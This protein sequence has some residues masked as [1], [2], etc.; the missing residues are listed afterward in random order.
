M[1]DGGNDQSKDTSGQTAKGDSHVKVRVAPRHSISTTNGIGEKQS[2]GPGAPV[3]LSPKEAE[4]LILSGYALPAVDEDGGAPIPNG[5]T[6]F[7]AEEGAGKVS[8]KED[9][10]KKYSFG[11]VDNNLLQN[12]AKVSIRMA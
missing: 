6:M 10:E 5:Y 7:K 12:G 4:R 9:S 3:W 11:K 2:H 8:I 1:A